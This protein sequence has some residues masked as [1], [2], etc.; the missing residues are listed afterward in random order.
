M[1]DPRIG[2]TISRYNIIEKIGEG[3]MGVVYKAIE[4]RL[5][6][7][8][9][10]KFLSAKALDSDD[11]RARFVRE[12][13]AAAALDHPNICTVYEIDEVE[14]ETFL[15][16]AF[17]EGQTVKANLRDRPLPLEEALDI[18]VQAAQGLDAAHEKGVVHRDIKCSNLM[19]GPRGQVK[20][21]DFGLA[22]LAD[23][24]K[25]TK[26]ATILGT[27][28]YMSPEQV[29]RKPTDRRTD[30]WSLAVVIYEMVTGRL[31]FE[32]EREQ[33]V[34]YAI[35]NE[36]PEPPTALRTRVPT[37]LDRIVGKA[38][39]KSRDE[40]YQHVDELLVDLKALRGAVS[41]DTTK[42]TAGKTATDAQLAAPVTRRRRT[43]Y[44]G[45]A[46]VAA[47]V[48]FS[49]AYW[50]GFS[51]SVTEQQSTPTALRSVPVTSH[52]G[53]ERTPAISPDGDQVAYSWNGPNSDN[54]DIY[55]QLIGAGRP[56][57]LTSN[58]AE[59][60]HPAWSPDGRY[61]AF[62][63]RVGRGA[64]AEVIQ[65]PA[66]GGVERKL[67]DVS[68]WQF[69]NLELSWSPDGKF[70]AIAHTAGDD[71][72]RKDIYSLS[73]ET[74]EKRLLA[75][76]SANAG[77]AL[78]FSPDGGRL[79]FAR[80]RVDLYVFDLAADGGPDGEPRRLT[81]PLGVIAGLDWSE[82]GHSVVYSARN[83]DGSDSLW[84]VPASGGVP[85]PV[86]AA[87]ENAAYPSISRRGNRLV[88]EE[89][90]FDDN[91]WRVPGLGHETYS[92][93]D[94]RKATR[95]IASTRSD[96]APYFSPDGLKLAF[97]SKR[98][99]TEQIWVS[100]ADGMNPVQVTSF[101]GAVP[102]SPTWSPDSRWI[103]FDLIRMA[104]DD[105]EGRA[106][107][108]HIY[109]MSA[110]GGASRQLTSGPS[111]DLHAA[112]SHDSRWVYFGS[113]RGG[114]WQIWKAPFEGGEPVQVTRGGGQ[115]AMAS[116]DGAFVYYTKARETQ[117]I[118]RVPVDGGDEEQVLERGHSGPGRWEI[119]EKGIYLL[120]D[121]GR[122]GA[123]RIE[124]FSFTT[125]RVETVAWLAE[126]TDSL[127]L[128]FTVSP[129]ERWVAYDRIDSVHSDI[130]LVEG[131]E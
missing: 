79:A 11:G 95:F 114:E 87:A 31:P 76:V 98:S 80:T 67:G 19:V 10:L 116:P 101:E 81:E 90:Q 25:L 4:T 34:L 12:A 103:M 131:F 78:A 23:G 58:P 115:E 84:Q 28:A 119:T 109:V 15:V 40:R 46:A 5:D 86:A 89:S 21:L 83:D 39:A 68:G 120:Y 43:L 93:V 110:A 54:F 129:D 42:S 111:Q 100:D 48:L 102:V 104:G 122:A 14:D 88:Y 18:A 52:A 118:W 27:P 56:L 35:V 36:E 106:F 8:V 45:L 49:A 91:I 29:E 24:S 16:M 124:F 113:E 99:G 121:E 63:R 47:V 62:V 74:G 6:R 17:L 105:M 85:E 61:I 66:L 41:G 71:P 26:T 38:M 37:E 92:A 2:R 22:Q 72:N 126:D 65:V 96:L 107:S 75:P 1:T 82:D 50:L 20:I 59:E 60:G 32:G 44:G 7:T 97:Q 123:N 70:L 30:T 64:E 117:V 128:Q 69:M 125:K 9:A 130:M 94:E 73:T 77:L 127:G 51:S 53:I 13:K 33:A 3:G 108:S 112:W 55:V 57:R